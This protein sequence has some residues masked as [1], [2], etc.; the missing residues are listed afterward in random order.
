MGR[1]AALGRDNPLARAFIRRWSLPSRYAGRD[2]ER[3]F[4]DWRWLPDRQAKLIH[5]SRYPGLSEHEGDPRASS[6]EARELGYLGRT[7]PA[8]LGDDGGAAVEV[9]RRL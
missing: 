6:R 3:S 7:P 1:R 9:A 8:F 4:A 5:S 2:I